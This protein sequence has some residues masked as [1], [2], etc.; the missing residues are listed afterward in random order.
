MNDTYEIRALIENWIIW[1]DTGDWD[2]FA[3]LWLPEGRMMTTWVEASAQDFIAGG[4]RAFN[5]GM[6]GMHSLGGTSVDVQGSRAVAQTRMQIMQRAPVHGVL[7]DVFCFGR[8]WDALEKR[9]GRWGLMFRQPIYELDR[10]SP[11][12]PN[13]TLTLDPELL[14]SFPEG[15]RHLAY[16]QTG[17]GFK[18]G[19]ALPGTRGPEVE[20]LYERGRRWLA[21]EEAAC[22]WTRA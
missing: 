17:L 10:I 6:K 20:A 3:T 18:I 5:E 19:K 14:A 22:L 13:D 16:L 11:V 21:G 7:A 9:D 2:R 12:N 8:F 4:R 1:R 15:Y